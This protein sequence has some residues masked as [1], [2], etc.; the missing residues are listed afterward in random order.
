MSDQPSKWLYG[1]EGWPPSPGITFGAPPKHPPL[2]ARQQ[3]FKDLKFGMFIHWGLD[4]LLWDRPGAWEEAQRDLHWDPRRLLGDQLARLG[5]AFAA[6]VWVDLAR[7]A[8]QRYLAFTT[9]HHLG[10]ANYRSQG[11]DYNSAVLGP[12]RD[13]LRE[14]ADECRRQDMPLVAYLSL[15]DA[16]HPDF[17]P[18]DAAV[19]DRYLEFLW[20]QMEELA[21]NYGPLAGFWLDPGP[22]N[23]PAYHYPADEIRDRVRQ[24]WPD[25][26]CFDWDESEQSYAHRDYL[27]TRGMVMAYE[28][29]PEQGPQPE[30]WPFEVCDTLNRTWF[31]QPADREYKDVRTLIQRLVEIVGRG[32]NYLLNHGPL[33]SGEVNPQDRQRLEAMGDWLHANG[34]AIYGTRPLGVPAQEWGWP[35]ARGKHIYLHLLRWPP[36]R[37]VLPR[38]LPVAAARWLHGGALEFTEDED[39]VTVHLPAKPVDDPVSIAVLDLYL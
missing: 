4:S 39:G 34:D 14:V 3:W 8:G 1:R 32:G 25:T 24:R 20:A 27:S 22:W 6:K 38:P 35:V 30:A 7:R 31:Y 19:W 16:R 33:P 23:G 5:E 28:I 26:L 11:H 10:F 29:H 18:L 17:R 15:S 21:D 37:I 9:K 2:T 13:F 12:K 36:D